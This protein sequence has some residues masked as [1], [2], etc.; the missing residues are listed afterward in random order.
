MYIY[1]TVNL[2]IIYRGHMYIIYSWYFNGMQV[3]FYYYYCYQTLN[4]IPRSYQTPPLYGP[5]HM[6][7]VSL[8]HGGFFGVNI[9]GWDS[10]TYTWVTIIQYPLVMSK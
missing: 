1:I 6:C 3:I 5:S 7:F 2:N 9:I 4:L 8:N 10:F